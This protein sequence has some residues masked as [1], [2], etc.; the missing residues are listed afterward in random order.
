MTSLGFCSALLLQWTARLRIFTVRS[1]LVLIFWGNKSIANIVYMSQNSFFKR[2]VLCPS[3]F[4]TSVNLLYNF[5]VLIRTELGVLVELIVL[6]RQIAHVQ[7]LNVAVTA[8]TEISLGR[9]GPAL[10]EHDKTVSRHALV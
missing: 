9:L 1:P 6:I 8:T 4:A 2:P 5:C 7:V 10:L 3:D